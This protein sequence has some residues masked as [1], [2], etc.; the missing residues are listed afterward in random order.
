[1]SFVKPSGLNDGHPESSKITLFEDFVKKIITQVQANPKLAAE[2]AIMITYDEGG[3]YW[4]SGYV[5]TLDFFGD[6]TRIPMIIV[7]P[8]TKGGHVSHVY[9]DHASIPKFIEANWGLPTISARSRDNMPN[10]VTAAGNPY[11]PI[12]GV[13]A[14]SDMMAAFNFT[15]N[16]TTKK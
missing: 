5:Q 8:Y 10:P 4:D 6:G 1:V 16:P 9:S 13:P 3:G 14:I 2:T 15:S 12:N 11:V 7:S